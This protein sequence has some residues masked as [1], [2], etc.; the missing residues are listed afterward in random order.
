MHIYCM[1]FIEL[2]LILLPSVLS[3]SLWIQRTS[4][5]LISIRALT[6]LILADDES[7]FLSAWLYRI[8]I[9]INNLRSSRQ[10]CSEI[11]IRLNVSGTVLNSYIMLR[12]KRELFI[13]RRARDLLLIP[14]CIIHW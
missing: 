6:F 9:Q 5:P 1:F 7:G 12:E 14:E 8:F 2:Q 3:D 4:I 10:S 11:Y 13:C